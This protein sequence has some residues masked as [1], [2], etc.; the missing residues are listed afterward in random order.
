M[1][2]IF[3]IFIL[4]LLLPVFATN[5]AGQNTKSLISSG[6]RALAG[7]DFESARHDYARAL[8]RT[9][10]STERIILSEKITWC[11][12]GLNMLN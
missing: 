6:D 8:E 2:H 3:K 12:N 10:D 9:Q 5:A 4:A 11:E 7:Y 1:K